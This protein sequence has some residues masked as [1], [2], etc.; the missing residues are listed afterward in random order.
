M[1]HVPSGKYYCFC[2]DLAPVK[3]KAE[4]GGEPSTGKQGE[5][6]KGKKG[7]SSKGKKGESGKD[8][9]GKKK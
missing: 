2:T 9:K 3:K 6:S 7:E 4:D 1:R 8:K 5:S